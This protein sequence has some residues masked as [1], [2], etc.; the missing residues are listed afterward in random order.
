[1]T[2]E[3][4]DSAE[5]REM[6]S[7][8]ALFSLEYG[9]LKKSCQ[10]C[11]CG[12]LKPSLCSELQVYKSDCHQQGFAL[13]VVCYGQCMCSHL[14]RGKS[15]SR[16]APSIQWRTPLLQN[17]TFKEIDIAPHYVELFE[18]FLFSVLLYLTT[19]FFS[20]FFCKQWIFTLPNHLHAAGMCCKQSLSESTHLCYFIKQPALRCK[21]QEWKLTAREWKWEETWEE[22]WWGCACNPEFTNTQ[23]H[24]ANTQNVNLWG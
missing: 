17:H 9:A 10:L 1:M 13:F 19:C 6:F 7:N 14:C 8:W 4:T 20:F 5:G 2:T 15:N 18:L 24:N 3:A 12:F 22:K 23:Q 11:A 21:Q 16:C